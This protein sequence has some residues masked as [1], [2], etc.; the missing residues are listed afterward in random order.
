ML[1]TLSFIEI[2]YILWMYNFFKTRYSFSNRT[3]RYLMNEQ[4]IA[5]FR[6]NRTSE[7]PELKICPFGQFFSVLFCLYIFARIYIIRKRGYSRYFQLINEIIM[8]NVAF[9]SYL[10]NLNAFVYLIPVF[11]YE[12]II[13][14][15]IKM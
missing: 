12:F 2:I 15:R 6:H 9:F 14:P 7:E 10:M 3:N 1:A 13:L 4:T 5:F 11:L 8:G